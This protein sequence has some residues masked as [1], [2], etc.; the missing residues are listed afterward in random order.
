MLCVTDELL[1]HHWGAAFPHMMRY[2]FQIGT[3]HKP[4][5]QKQSHKSRQCETAGVATKGEPKG[6]YLMGIPKGMEVS[7]AAEESWRRSSP[8]AFFPLHES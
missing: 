6:G 3:C 5:C 8:A 7:Q 2:R 1:A 4:T